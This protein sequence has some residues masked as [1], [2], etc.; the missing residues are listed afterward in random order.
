MGI[1]LD[2]LVAKPIKRQP[3][4][5]V[6]RFFFA[7]K[8]EE[9]TLIWRNELCGRFSAKTETRLTCKTWRISALFRYRLRKKFG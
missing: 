1:F 7:E 2:R 5:R 6:W 9:S 4:M 8:C 3:I